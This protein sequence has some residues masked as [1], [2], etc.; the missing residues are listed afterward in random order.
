MPKRIMVVDD[1]LHARTLY[2]IHLTRDTDHLVDAFEDPEQA[3][4]MMRYGKRKDITY[5]WLITD[6]NMFS[7]SGIDLTKKVRSEFGKTPSIVLISG[8]EEIKAKA[9]EAG[10]DAFFLKPVNFI[11]L[12]LLIRGLQPPQEDG[13]S[14]SEQ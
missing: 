10:V 9:L 3:L 4:E 7:M 12:D 11:H 13:Y 2:T 6:Y 14:N 5:D 8:M 1:D